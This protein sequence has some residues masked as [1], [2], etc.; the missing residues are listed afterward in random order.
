MAKH[1]EDIMIVK[2]PLYSFGWNKEMPDTGKSFSDALVVAS[3]N[4][5]YDKRLFMELQQY[6]EL[7]NQVSPENV[8]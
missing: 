4:P 8:A 5:Q 6:L 2:N 1:F 7:G 3:T